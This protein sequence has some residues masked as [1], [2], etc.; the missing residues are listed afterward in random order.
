MYHFNRGFRYF[1]EEGRLRLTDVEAENEMAVG[2]RACAIGDFN[3]DGYL[4]LAA[5][6]D[7]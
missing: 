2:Q 5:A 1:G 3:R 7:I 4:D 6:F